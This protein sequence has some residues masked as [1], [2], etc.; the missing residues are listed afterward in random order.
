MFL[1]KFGKSVAILGAL[2]GLF[3]AL[4]LSRK[5]NNGDN[6]LELLCKFSE[7]YDDM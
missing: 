4:E 2:N 6:L 7:E 3:A 1:Q 5:A